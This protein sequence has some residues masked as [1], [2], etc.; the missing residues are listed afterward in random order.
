MKLLRGLMR[1]D[2]LFQKDICWPIWILGLLGYLILA[3]W[4]IGASTTGENA[5]SAK[6]DRAAQAALDRAGIPWARVS[7]DGQ[8]AVISGYAPN[9][10]A[11]DLAKSVVK[12][13]AGP[14]GF[15]RGGV[16]KTRDRTTLA[17]APDAAVRWLAKRR[18]DGVIIL[19]GTAPS[20]TERTDLMSA[21][22][23]LFAAP[24]IDSMTAAQASAHSGWAGPARI[25]LRLMSQMPDG[26]AELSGTRLTV[27]GTAPNDA[28]VRT[29]LIDLKALP[30]PFT[31]E[32]AIVAKM[33][34]PELHGADLAANTSSVADCQDA[35]I[36]IMA[37]NKINFETATAVLG[38]DNQA[39]LDKIAY[40]SKRCSRFRIDVRGHTDSSGARP[41][42]LA[43]SKS[44]AD[45]VVA[46]LVSQGVAPQR[47][48]SQGFGPDR[49]IAPN[50]S[51]DGMARN[52]RIDFAVR[53]D[54]DQ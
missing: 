22:R 32:S 39:T 6:L 12:S 27:R 51:P 4:A 11:R 16:T 40:V 26:E 42:N 44:R 9:Q 43:L 8:A 41:S 46:Y 50:T 48:S 30:Q 1:S 33:A 49:P 54:G 10:A 2:G 37:V 38:A 3:W 47:L 29:A 7:M 19:T 36:K 21:A 14:G 15:F 28:F 25:G 35:F 13:A 20:I 52:R 5:V 45:A 34:I 31:G 17:A 18:E 23:S 24:V 53:A